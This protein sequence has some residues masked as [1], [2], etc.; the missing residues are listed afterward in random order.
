M[1]EERKPKID[2]KARLGKASAG[3]PAPGAAG[4][5]LPV[6]PPSMGSRPPPAIP[7]PVVPGIPVGPPSPFGSSAAPGPAIDPSNP[8]AA[9]AAPYRPQPTAPPQPQRIEV[10]EAAVQQA[11]GS[12]R[13][14]GAVIALITAAVFCGVGY[15]AGQASEA[16]SG[17][18]KAKADATELA[19]DVGK[20]K[21]Q[22]KDLAAK[23]DAGR[24]SIGEKKF[25]D[26]LSKDLGAIHVDFDGTKLAGRRFSGFPTEVT[27][28]LVEFITGVQAL[29]DKKDLVVGLL[30]RLQKP[31]TE[32][33]AAPPGQTTVNFVVAVDKDPAG[34]PFGILGRLTAPVTFT[35]PQIT[36]PP[37]FT[38]TNPLTGGTSEAPA[39][40]TGDISRN[41][42]AIYVLP[43]SFDSVCTSPTASEAAQ[44]AASIGSL[45]RDINGEPSQGDMPV[46][47]KPGLSERADRLLD[48][49]THRVK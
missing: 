29:N 43:K 47:T 19:G 5:P 10:D 28:G 21:D 25:P 44:L 3:T 24:K 33:F 15:V 7:P 16:G 26:Q 37:K 41:P 35:P 2:L 30:T 49:L 40:K 4:V 34:N 9:V 27:G 38:F 45:L 39:Y 14:Q 23:L 31:L 6:P 8:L 1:A 11:R 17:R 48:G 46:E 32:Q 12:A 42:A 20:A 13:K 22:L 18:A 36:V